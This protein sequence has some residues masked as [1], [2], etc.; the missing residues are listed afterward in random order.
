[1]A[2]IHNE[3]HRYGDVQRAI[4][5][6][7]G[8]SDAEG[9]V[10]RFGETLQPVLDLFSRKEWDWPRGARRFARVLTSPAVVARFSAFQLI[11]IPTSKVLVEIEDLVALSTATVNA[12]IGVDGASTV[13]LANPVGVN[14]APMDGRGFPPGLAVYQPI[15]NLVIGDA[16][17]VVGIPQYRF[18]PSFLRLENAGIILTPKSSLF[19]I[20]NAVNLALSFI[21]R[22]LERPVIPDELGT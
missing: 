4:K 13:S 9:G 18:T 10:E 12:D 6:V 20:A 5:N 3:L 22:W 11:N 21:V 14:H 19:I 16:G 17:A 2:G 8:S 7:V 15:L 1:M